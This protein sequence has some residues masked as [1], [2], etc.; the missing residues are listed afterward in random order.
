MF[1][2]RKYIENIIQRRSTDDVTGYITNI[3]FPQQME[4]SPVNSLCVN[5]RT[6]SKDK[7][8]LLFN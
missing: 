4:Y 7:F 5:D 2:H 6:R 8:V 1:E 3:L